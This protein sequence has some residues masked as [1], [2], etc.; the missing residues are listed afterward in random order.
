MPLNISTTCFASAK[1][2]NLFTVDWQFCNIQIYSASLILFKYG[3]IIGIII[4]SLGL[5]LTAL[6]IIGEYIYSIHIETKY[7]PVY[8]AKKVVRSEDKI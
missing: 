1:T 8:I 5:I 7:R 3:I 2:L 6:G 4:L